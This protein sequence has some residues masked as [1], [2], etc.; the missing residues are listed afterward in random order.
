MSGL[1]RLILGA[2]RVLKVLG[3]GSRSLRATP[4]LEIPEADLTHQARSLSAAMMRVNHAGEVC[5]QALYDGQALFA[6]DVENRRWLEAAGAEEAD[7]LAWTAQRVREL[8]GR[9]SA[10]NPI[11]YAGSLVL[12]GVAARLG[13]RVSLGFLRET[14]RQVVA[15]LDRHLAELPECDARSRAI[16]EAMKAEEAMHADAAARRGGVGLPWPV[17]CLMRAAARIMTSVARYV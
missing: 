5:A 8:G 11:W 17:P 12:G 10:L 9:T 4:A 7:H 6:Q 2:D 1:D 15:H 16:V 14:E 13:D 3:G